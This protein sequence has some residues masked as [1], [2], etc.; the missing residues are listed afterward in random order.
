MAPN[1]REAL[2]GFAE[3]ALP[4][5]PGYCLQHGDH[6]V[7]LRPASGDKGTAIRALLEEPPFRGRLPVFAGDDLTDESGFAVVNAQGGHSV[8]VG[9][10]E[11]SAAHYA[12]RDAAAL[13]DWV[14]SAGRGPAHGGNPP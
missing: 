12:L 9:T 10:R 6:V 5:L 7:E 3:V 11:P 14:G 13:R 8:L 4:R 2:R 1:A